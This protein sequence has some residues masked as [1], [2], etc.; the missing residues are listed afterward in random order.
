MWTNLC[1][2]YWPPQL[3]VQAAGS[4]LSLSWPAPCT[5]LVLE[6][7]ADLTT[8][9]WVTVPVSPVVSNYQNIVTVP[10]TN[11]ITYFRLS[12]PPF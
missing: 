11:G 8:T 7:N 12:G 6:E 5:G 2:A 10:A 9:N 4:N 3:S 1:I